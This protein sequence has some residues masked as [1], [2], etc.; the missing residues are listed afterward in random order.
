MFIKIGVLNFTVKQLCWSLFLIKLQASV[1]EFNID[2]GLSY[3]EPDEEEFCTLFNLQSLIKKD[4]C[5]K[6]N[7]KSITDLILTNKPNFSK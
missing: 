1:G 6:N 7:H 2:I 5:F 3:G 4:T